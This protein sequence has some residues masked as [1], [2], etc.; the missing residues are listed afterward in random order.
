MFAKRKENFQGNNPIQLS[1][2]TQKC[3]QM[4]HE[5]GESLAGL[6][7][8]VSKELKTAHVDTFHAAVSSMSVEVPGR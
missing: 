8:S 3:Y 5:E 6:L 1:Q 7:M 4:L 2:E